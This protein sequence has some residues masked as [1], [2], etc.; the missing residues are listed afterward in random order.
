MPSGL[1]G[2]VQLVSYLSLE[3][4]AGEITNQQDSSDILAFVLRLD[5][6]VGEVDFTTQLISAL[7]DTLDPDDQTPVQS[8]H[9]VQQAFTTLL[10]AV[11]EVDNALNSDMPIPGMETGIENLEVG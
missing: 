1:T 9:K 3:D 4:L 10:Q 8:Y 6:L 2:N 11:H 5:E 7:N